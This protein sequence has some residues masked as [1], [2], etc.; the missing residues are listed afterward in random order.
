MEAIVWF[1]I[2]PTEQRDEA[3]TDPPDVRRTPRQS[4]WGAPART[5]GGGLAITERV[6]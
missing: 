5:V 4:R 3:G 2:P 6:P 1:A